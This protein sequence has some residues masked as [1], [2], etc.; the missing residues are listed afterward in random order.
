MKDEVLTMLGFK[1]TPKEGALPPFETKCPHCGADLSFDEN[2]N[3]LVC[4]K[5]KNQVTFEEAKEKLRLSQ[6]VTVNALMAS[7]T[8]QIEDGDFESADAALKPALQLMPYAGLLHVCALLIEYKKTS[9][10]KLVEVGPELIENVHYKSALRYLSA[11]DRLDLQAIGNE[12]SPKP[13]PKEEPKPQPEPLPEPSPEPEPLPEPEPAPEPEPE[14]E[15]QP[16]PAPIPEPIPEP[17]PQP[18]PEPIPEPIPEPRPEPKPASEPKPVKEQKPAEKSVVSPDKPA[19]PGPKRKIDKRTLHLLIGAGCVVLTFLVFAI[20]SF[21]GAGQGFGAGITLGIIALLVSLG[22]AG[23]TLAC[24]LKKLEVPSFKPL[25]FILDGVAVLG[26]IGSILVGVLPK[27][28]NESGQEAATSSISSDPSQGSSALGPKKL[29][30]HGAPSADLGDVGDTYIDLDT[31]TEYLKTEQGW[32]ITSTTSS[33]S[34][35][36]EISSESSSATSSSSESSSEVS[37]SSES[38]SAISSE[39]SSESSASSSSES[40]I[41]SS[42]SI[43]SSVVPTV[44]NASLATKPTVEGKGKFAFSI[45]GGQD[46]GDYEIA[47]PSFNDS[48]LYSYEDTEIATMDETGKGTYTLKDNTVGA[49]AQM[50]LDKSLVVDASSKDAS[51]VN[52]Q[53]VITAIGDNFSDLNSLEVVTPKIPAKDAKFTSKGFTAPDA[54][55]EGEFVFEVEAGAW[56]ETYGLKLPKFKD[57]LYYSVT[58]IPATRTSSEIIRR[59]LTESDAFVG[60]KD[61]IYDSWSEGEGKTS[62]E[63]EVRTSTEMEWLSNQFNIVLQGL[64][65]SNNIL[66]YDVEGSVPKFSY[67][68]KYL[69]DDEN[70]IAAVTGVED[71]YVDTLTVIDVPDELILDDKS[72]KVVLVA[73]EAFRGNNHIE[74][75][76]FGANVTDLGENCFEGAINMK[77]VTFE[78]EDEGQM[79]DLAPK[80]FYVCTSLT[81]ING[82]KR[83][84]TIQGQCFEG[85]TA[86]ESVAFGSGLAVVGTKSFKDC[87]ALTSFSVEANP[88]NETLYVNQEAFSGCSALSSVD[89]SSSTEAGDINIADSTFADCKALASFVGFNRVSSIG[90]AAFY[91]CTA[92]ATAIAFGDKLDSIGDYA[93]EGCVK[94]PSVSFAGVTDLD[95]A[96]AIIGKYAFAYCTGMTALTLGTDV[97]CIGE[98]SFFGCANLLGKTVKLPVNLPL[99]NSTRTQGLAPAAFAETGAYLTV[100]SGA[101]YYYQK[102]NIIWTKASS[103]SPWWD[104]IVYVNVAYRS[105]YKFPLTDGDHKLNPYEVY[106]YAF[107]N[108]TNLKEVKFTSNLLRLGSHA[109]EGLPNLEVCDLSE[110]RIITIEEATFKDCPRL[111]RIGASDDPS[112]IASGG[113]K[114]SAIRDY[115]FANTGFTSLDFSKQGTSIGMIIG[116]FVFA[117]SENLTKV[118]FPTFPEK[119]TVTFVG[120]TSMGRGCFHDCPDFEAIELANMTKAQFDENFVGEGTYDDDDD[121]ATDPVAWHWY[122]DLDHSVTIKF[123]GDSTVYNIYTTYIK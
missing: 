12:A 19:E 44:I 47:L 116:D 115:A 112:K 26:L 86:L 5:C 58:K 103:T 93:F 123:K 92:L 59:S 118:I 84:S 20:V 37:S 60:F 23:V 24:Y 43:P 98:Y 18:E 100:A 95:D 109:F 101:D 96:N 97:K 87:T 76:Y 29:S 31:G 6:E 33:S 80:A 72:Y 54:D 9:P 122:D 83:I 117:G 50:L 32:I 17:V 99:I 106:A 114:I 4:P 90:E 66:N 79:V 56:K 30:G 85:D 3:A 61:R 74:K 57:D 68:L 65:T 34:S 22:M 104:T 15:P 28:S 69:T 105:D 41:S 113:M 40:S 91:G 78:K 75:A 107:N 120:T 77:E 52:V 64:Y 11:E 88:A 10:G 94:I 89:L 21:V 2:V 102:E 7:L 81:T 51:S 38:S 73:D 46:E 42:S 71:D 49:Y 53:Y 82:A 14:P 48:T 39:S 36:S 62:L 8:G 119:E 16:E 63:A 55:S 25:P 108:C 27:G 70:G 110:T 111:T 67:Q 35:S 1:E 13:E 121:P 45:A